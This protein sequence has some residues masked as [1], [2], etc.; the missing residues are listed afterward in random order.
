MMK[1]ISIIL[2]FTVAVNNLF[3][4]T[5]KSSAPI[6]WQ[7][8][9]V[10]PN[11][12]SVLLP[13]MPILIHWSDACS[14]KE[15]RNYYAYAGEVVYSLKIT[16]KTKEK[17]PQWCSTKEKF[18][19]DNFEERIQEIR[20]TSETIDEEKFTPE[21]REVTRITLKNSTVWLFDDL[22]NKRWF[23]LSVSHRENAKMDTKA[24]V[25]SIK[26]KKNPDGIEIGEG[27][28]RTLGDE[29][30]ADENSSDV[31]TSEKPSAAEENQGLLIIAKPKPR[32][33]D[34]A[35]RANIRGTVTLKVTFLA[36][37]GIGI[38]TPVS[39]LSHGLTEQA[40]IAVKKLVF[41]PQKKGNQTQT[42][43]KSIQFGFSIY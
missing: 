5:E 4:Q 41:L 37:G 43:V 29:K 16:A 6:D 9:A 24:F 40:I 17:A 20:K 39:E 10:A 32:Y 19:R 38:I 13:K 28:E 22:T 26:F 42:V 18:S 34:A 21:D 12:V 27:S 35:R 3:A 36:N 1:L 7:R 8:Y 23:E 15:I 11:E 25:E 33:T 31:N 30:A 2:F 14:E